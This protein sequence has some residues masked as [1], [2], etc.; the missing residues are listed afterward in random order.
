MTSFAFTFFLFVDLCAI[1]LNDNLWAVQLADQFPSFSVQKADFFIKRANSHEIGSV[2]QMNWFYSHCIVVRLVSEHNTFE[3][4]YSI[5]SVIYRIFPRYNMRV[6]SLPPDLN[7][8]KRIHNYAVD[9]FP[10][11]TVID[12]QHILAVMLL[13][14]SH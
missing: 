1:I 4:T 9:H 14:K 7:Q 13:K 5:E 8:I 6:I 2:R 10:I 11:S 3:G 12:S